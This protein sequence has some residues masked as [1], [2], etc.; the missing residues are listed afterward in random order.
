MFGLG[1]SEIMVIAVLGLILLGPEQLPDLAR[2]LGRFINDLKRS[3]EGLS[4]EFRKQ[5]FG[6]GRKLLDELR[7]ETQIDP[8]NLSD[9]FKETLDSITTTTHD[10][11]EDQHSEGSHNKSE[12][13]NGEK[14]E[15]RKKSDA[16]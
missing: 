4:E 14:N 11:E 1:F 10:S 16:D 7:R 5:G 13:I 3:T 6:D 15:Q 12:Q 9:T 2:T 8:P